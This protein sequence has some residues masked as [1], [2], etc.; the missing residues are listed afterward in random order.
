MFC[1]WLAGGCAPSTKQWFRNSVSFYFMASSSSWATRVISAWS[2]LEGKGIW[3]LW[4]QE[5]LWGRSQSSI[6]QNTAVTW[7]R[8]TSCKRGWKKQSILFKGKR[9]EVVHSGV[10]WCI[11]GLLK[12]YEATWK[13]KKIVIW[14]HLWFGL[15]GLIH[16]FQ[17]VNAQHQFHFYFGSILSEVL[18]ANF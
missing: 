1:S 12:S 3:S 16:N 15:I 7:Q 14:L 5:F 9:K 2:L 4:S 8:V 6:G 10:R 17:Q 13:I 18:W 11:I